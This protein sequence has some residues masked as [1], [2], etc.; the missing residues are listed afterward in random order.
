MSSPK[1]VLVVIGGSYPSCKA[2]LDE[3]IDVESRMPHYANSI[4]LTRIVLDPPASDLMAIVGDAD[5]RVKML[6]V[7]YAPVDPNR[8]EDPYV[9]FCR[10]LARNASPVCPVVEI[11]LPIQNLSLDTHQVLVEKLFM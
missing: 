1:Q 6:V 10:E 9:K 11:I 7:N 3:L 2:F 8:E 5:T 4:D